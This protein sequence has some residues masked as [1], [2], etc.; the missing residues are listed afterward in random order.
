MAQTSEHCSKLLPEFVVDEAVEDD[1]TE[2][3]DDTIDEEVHVDDIDTI[4]GLAGAEPSA[5]D[6][7][8]LPDWVHRAR[9][10]LSDA[11]AGAVD[12]EGVVIVVVVFGAEINENFIR[13]DEDADV[14]NDDDIEDDDYDDDDDDDDQDF[15]ML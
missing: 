5:D 11:V 10:A 2:E 13:H 15:T 9:V 6:D 14:D 3:G 7:G 12:R 8:V 4:V 1:E